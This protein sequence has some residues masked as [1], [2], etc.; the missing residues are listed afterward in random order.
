VSRAA[1]DLFQ[2]WVTLLWHNLIPS[3]I[4]EDK[5]VGV[6]AALRKELTLLSQKRLF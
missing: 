2:S 1:S 5:I 6:K 3:G 4:R